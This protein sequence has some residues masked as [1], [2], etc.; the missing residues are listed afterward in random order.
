L[1]GTSEA[2][3]TS[4]LANVLMKLHSIRNKRI[5]FI[6]LQPAFEKSILFDLRQE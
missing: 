4:A 2:W 3:A 1:T 5:F 6:L